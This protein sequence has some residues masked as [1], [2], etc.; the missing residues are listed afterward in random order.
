[1]NMRSFYFTAVIGVIFISSCNNSNKKTT[2]TRTDSVVAIKQDK[3]PSKIK[4]STKKPPII[5]VVDTIEPK[6]I[7]VYLKDSAATYERIS[8]K[9]GQIYGVRLAEFF[10]KNS[11]K[12]AGAPMAWY[13][14]H[15]APYYF[16]A[17]VPVNKIPKK[18]MAGIKVKEL[19][20]DSVIMAHFYGPYDLMNVGYD[21]LNDWLKDHKRTLKAP[22]YEIY[23]SDPIDKKGKP[24]DPYKV[25][26]DI[27]FPWK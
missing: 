11:L 24:V 27:I 13:L 2:D 15:Q 14:T 25:Q 18:L 23:I 5:N 19:S 10:K 8:M 3:P 1:M 22:A 17:G 7:I 12:I 4:T 6:R 9:L 20:A 16:E 26:T 21:V